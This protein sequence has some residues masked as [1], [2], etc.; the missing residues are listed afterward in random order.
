[1]LAE[2][3]ALAK[4]FADLNRT[5]PAVLFRTKLVDLDPMSPEDAIEV[6]HGTCSSASAQVCKAVLLP[7]CRPWKL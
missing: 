7:V 2:Q 1:V 5:Y 6:C 4:E 3:E